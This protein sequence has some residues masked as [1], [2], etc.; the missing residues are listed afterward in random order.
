M[1]NVRAALT[2]IDHN[3]LL[4]CCFFLLAFIPLYPKIPLFDALP[5]YIVKVRVEDFLVVFTGLVWLI[6]VIRKRIE[7]NISYFWF[8]ALYA[9]A[10][11]L[12]IALGATLLNT[13]PVQLLHIGKSGLTWARYLE[14]FSLLFFFFS[15]I[16]TKRHIAITII[17]CMLTLLG[18]VGYG[19]GQKYA[20]FPVYSTMN[21]E[22]SKGEKLYLQAGAKPQSTFAGH[23][24]L[25][26][27]LVII[28]PI[29]FSLA[30]G[31]MR[32]KFTVK[33]WGIAIVI[34]GVHLTGLFMLVLTASATALGG[35]GIAMIIVALFHLWR[36][37]TL[38]TRLAWGAIALLLAFI[39]L[40]GVWF[41]AP[42][43]T[44]EKAVGLLF[45]KSSSD[46]PTDLLG[47]G[48]EDKRV[49]T[50]QPDGTIKYTIV[51]QKS[52]W[53][54]NALKYGISMGIR[55]DTL[56]PQAL[57]GLARSP[58]SG[59]GYGTLAMLDTQ[60]FTEADSTDNN[61]LR[62]LGETGLVGFILFYGIIF[63]VALATFKAGKKSQDET[64]SGLSIG[65]FGAVIGL[66]ITAIYLDVFAAS[67]VAFT[68]WALT[69]VVLRAIYIQYPAVLIAPVQKFRTHF[70]RHWPLYV[71][72]VLAFFLLHQNP[73]LQHT[74]TK[75]IENM[76][77]GLQNLT[78]A[79]C[80]NSVG[81]LS[82]CRNS[83]LV[84][85]SHL[86]F[87]ALLLSLLLRL[88][89]VYGVFAYL[90][91]M[92]IV[93]SLIVTYLLIRK[94]VSR[95]STIVILLFG[96]GS[97][98]L[99]QLTQSPLPE[100][101]FWL[102]V[103][104]PLLALGLT[105]V[106]KYKPLRIIVSIF[107]ILLIVMAFVHTDF[108][109]R[110]QNRVPNFAT[111]SI[112]VANN[113]IAKSIAKPAYL[114]S[115]LNPYFADLYTLP[116]Y[117]LLPLSSHQQY[118][119]HPR[120]IWEQTKSP[121][122]LVE[123]S[124]LFVSDYQAQTGQP[125]NA[126]FE[127]VKKAFDT[128]YVRLG[129]NELCN[130]YKLTSPKPIVSA[131]PLAVFTNT[132]MAVQKLPTTYQFAVVPNDF[133]PNLQDSTIFYTT[134]TFTKRL[135]PLQNQKENFMVLTGDAVHK[136]EK[137]HANFTQAFA[138]ATDFP[139]LYAQGNEKLQPI[140]YFDGEFQSF[141]TPT[142]YFILLDIQPDS[143][144]GDDEKLRLYDAF[145]QIEKLPN[146]QSVFI[147]SHDLNW[148]NT[149]DP[150]N[151]MHAIEK[152]L[153]AFPNLHTYILTANHRNNL[154]KAE[155]W[156]ET[157]TSR[158]VTYAAALTAGNTRDVS[159]Q[160]QVNPRNVE[161]NPLQLGE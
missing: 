32:Q 141:F 114:M 19:I 101:S 35:Y 111:E 142:E 137:V 41:I 94:R 48:Y 75:D 60:G 86:S 159:F 52:T 33:N 11:L 87:Y 97:T 122:E 31:K 38:K 153:A 68:F 160:V 115:S 34:M 20:H 121:N 27:Y 59:S 7:W 100:L 10:G 64:T 22:Y 71:I 28:L 61:F 8:V 118:A 92:L 5:G 70:F 134:A 112:Q 103:L 85:A 93:L 1:K 51:R 30:L 152:K 98:S 82:L 116:N 56:W 139:I 150:E 123:T 154:M 135:L 88:T 106:L 107:S 113:S 43:T 126:D 144:I 62:T 24:D 95:Q 104:Y 36:L 47:D 125:Y 9:I 72:I 66:C 76:T 13:I 57:L 79:K 14:Y 149:S 78:A 6:G 39:G 50:A 129:C 46:I 45:G 120:N 138:F 145:L 12:S 147:I 74:P 18:V 77:A 67:K 53:S 4:L 80:L 17:I 99:H 110:F 58:L 89:P 25:A 69:G 90:N 42:A 161:I 131:D 102:L 148:Q 130:I 2:W 15:A 44:K 63:S 81:S 55:L 40:A 26:A 156:Y 108:L 136:P 151:A 124:N 16:K 73:F 105:F 146:I 37:P 119:D 158:N 140:K 29:L 3:L 133:D 21:R 109:L 83:G 49:G 117:T 132:R 96:V 128:H 127:T 157:K 84:S 23:Y 54:A 155:S 65:L 143:H 91:L